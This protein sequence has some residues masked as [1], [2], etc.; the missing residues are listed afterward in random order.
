M[1]SPQKIVQREGFSHGGLFPAFET[2]RIAGTF[3]TMA[4]V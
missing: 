2:D 3:L 1:L 4:D